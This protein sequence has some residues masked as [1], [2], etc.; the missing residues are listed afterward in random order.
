V[1]IETFNIPSLLTICILSLAIN[2]Q[3]FPYLG[4]HLPLPFSSLHY[5]SLSIQHCTIAGRPLW[6]FIN[7]LAIFQV[8][9]CL[10][11]TMHIKEKHKNL[12][13]YCLCE[14]EILSPHNQLHNSLST[15]KNSQCVLR[16]S[17]HTIICLGHPK[18]SMQLLKLVIAEL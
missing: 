8:N 7:L 4:M 14:V 10:K 15:Q 9:H 5:K 2:I 13:F 18:I 12:P 6:E 3:Y 11:D 1:R 16:K 17:I